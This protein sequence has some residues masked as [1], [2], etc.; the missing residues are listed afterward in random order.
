MAQQKHN[1]NS[2]TDFCYVV[3]DCGTNTFHINIWQ[4]LEHDALTL[5]YADRIPVF[6]WPEHEQ[7]KLVF[8]AAAV[9]RMLQALK[10]FALHFKN[11]ENVKC[12]AVGTAAFRAAENAQEVIHTLAFETGIHIQ[13]LTG[14]EEA[15]W[16]AKGII[17]QAMP[18]VVDGWIMDIGGGSTEFICVENSVIKHCFSF[19]AGVSRLK[20]EFNIHDPIQDTELKHITLHLDQCFAALRLNSNTLSVV[21]GASG[22]FDTVDALCQSQFNM[23]PAYWSKEQVLQ[24]C[25]TVFSSHAKT[26]LQWEGLIPMRRET[27][28]QSA[29][30]IHWVFSQLPFDTLIVETASLKEGLIFGLQH[31]TLQNNKI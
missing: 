26:R 2:K 3:I 28:V 12:C 13:I 25:N 24:W 9:Q 21:Y 11:H 29:L 30:L 14:E 19:E 23:K 15:F 31:G 4:T 6:I 18:R 16:I 5:I 1:I 8:T 27:I 22:V 20:S 7:G 10:Q 17:H